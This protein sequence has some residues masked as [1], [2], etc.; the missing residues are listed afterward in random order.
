M[1]HADLARQIELASEACDT[2]RQNLMKQKLSEGGINALYFKFEFKRQHLFK[3][4]AKALI[5]IIPTVRKNSSCQMTLEAM[6]T[7]VGL[8]KYIE[9]FESREPGSYFNL[10]GKESWL[11]LHN[12]LK[13]EQPKFWDQFPKSKELPGLRAN[14][15]ASVLDLVNAVS[16][17][18]H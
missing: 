12:G 10:K 3:L 15:G 14:W 7:V 1:S 4:K 17:K 2:A 9:N 13:S 5:E 11:Q 8:A 6:R 16:R 18:G